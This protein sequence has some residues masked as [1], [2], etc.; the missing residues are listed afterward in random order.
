M[1]I[2]PAGGGNEADLMIEITGTDLDE[3]N[4]IADEVKVLVAN[5]NGTTDIESSYRSGVPEIEIIPNRKKLA[6]HSI[7]AAQL[8]TTL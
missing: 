5:T 2:S 6:D 3:L 7:S 4:R 1:T 8:A